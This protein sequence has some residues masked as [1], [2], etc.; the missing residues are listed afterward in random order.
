MI[1]LFLWYMVHAVCSERDMTGNVE[2]VLHMDLSRTLL[3]FLV[4]DRSFRV[5]DDHGCSEDCFV[6]ERSG[7]AGLDEECTT[8]AG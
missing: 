5:I 3:V 6:P 2:L 1:S 7:S 4:R 8:G